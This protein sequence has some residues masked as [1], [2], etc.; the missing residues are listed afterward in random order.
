[1][2][3]KYIEGNHNAPPLLH[4]ITIPAKVPIGSHAP[5]RGNYFGARKAI[6]SNC[7]SALSLKGVPTFDRYAFVSPHKT[8]T[9]KKAAKTAL[10][11]F[12]V[13]K[14]GSKR[15]RPIIRPSLYD[16]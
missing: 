9:P 6:L 2:A 5:M 1:L 3:D 10:G 7:W 15:S 14:F 4:W 12:F 11:G 13:M 16:T 8:Y